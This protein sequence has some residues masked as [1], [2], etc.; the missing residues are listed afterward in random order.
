MAIPRLR[1]SPWPALLL[2]AMAL[3]AC[4]GTPATATPF[5]PPTPTPPNWDPITLQAPSEATAGAEISVG[6]TGKDVLGDYVVVVPVGTKQVTDTTPYV[7]ASVGNPLKIT[8]PATA[9][10][11]EIWFVEGDTADHIKARQPLTVK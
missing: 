4:G 8:V 2:L 3:A 11:Y 5:V 1:L 7:N 9:G 6:W 10:A